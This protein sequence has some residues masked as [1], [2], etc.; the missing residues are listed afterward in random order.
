MKNR[1]YIILIGIVLLLAT[2]SVGFYLKWKSDTSAAPLDVLSQVRSGMTFEEVEALLG[3]PD[4]SGKRQ[5]DPGSFPDTESRRRV[6]EVQTLWFYRNPTKA[7][8]VRLEFREDGTL[9]RYLLEPFMEDNG[10]GHPDIAPG[11]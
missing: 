11:S 4:E 1:L 7:Y 2:T 6:Y 10:F 5:I 3:H 9:L 8:E